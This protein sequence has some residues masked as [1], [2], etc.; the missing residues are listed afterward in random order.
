[1]VISKIIQKEKERKKELLDSSRLMISNRDRIEKECDNYLHGKNPKEDYMDNFRRYTQLEILK[2]EMEKTLSELKS[3]NQSLIN[4]KEY[5]EEDSENLKTKLE[6][7]EEKLIKIIGEL[8][9]PQAG[10]HKVIKEIFLDEEKE[11]IAELNKMIEK[12]SQKS[13]Q[14]KEEKK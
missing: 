3:Q 14:A 6:V 9:Y 13:S 1:M 10:V 7:L 11:D 8:D 2:L 4:L 12:Y 5:M